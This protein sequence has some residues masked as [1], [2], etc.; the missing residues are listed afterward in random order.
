MHI[1]IYIYR[2]YTYEYTY[3]HIHMRMHIC[4]HIKLKDVGISQPWIPT[5][6]EAHLRTGEGTVHLS[7]LTA[8]E[9]GA[10]A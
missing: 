3:I 7:Q 5:C 4:I 9:L 10:G 6:P 2:I 1:D 8:T